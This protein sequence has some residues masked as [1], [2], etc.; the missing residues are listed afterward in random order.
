MSLKLRKHTELCVLR[1]GLDEIPAVANESKHGSKDLCLRR[2]GLDGSQRVDQ[3]SKVENI[4]YIL[5]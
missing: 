3:L 4:M 2:P 1:V 5:K